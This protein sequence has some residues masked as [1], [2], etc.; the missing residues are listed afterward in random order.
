GTSLLQ[1]PLAAPCLSRLAVPDSRCSAYFFVTFRNQNQNRLF[2]TLHLG[3][4]APPVPSPSYFLQ[5][6]AFPVPPVAPQPH[7]CVRRDKPS[8][9]AIQL[10]NF[11]HP[12]TN[13]KRQT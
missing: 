12:Y 4:P 10:R 8:V 11:K 13:T 5:P 2:Q 6:L 1:D 3:F 7:L 9:V